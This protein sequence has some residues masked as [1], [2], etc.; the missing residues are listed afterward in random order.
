MKVKSLFLSLLYV[1]MAMTPSAWA[2]EKPLSVLE[3]RMHRE[4]S[5]EEW[6]KMLEDDPK[7]SV[8]VDFFFNL[9][10]VELSCQPIVTCHHQVMTVK[11]Q[12][13]VQGEQELQA[14]VDNGVS[15]RLIA[16]SEIPNAINATEKA[17]NRVVF[18]MKEPNVVRVRGLKQGERVQ[19]FNAAGLAVKAATANAGGEATLNLKSCATGIYVVSTGERETFKIVKK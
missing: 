8:P 19:A 14:N 12:D 11:W 9:Y 6:E 2:V 10:Y 7:A 17:S 16:P 15:M 3:I 13:S 18:D 1:M 4:G 5:I